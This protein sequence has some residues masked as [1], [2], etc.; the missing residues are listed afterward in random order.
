MSI[1][2]NNTTSILG[3]ATAVPKNCIDI[4]QLK[5][6]FKIDEVTAFVQE[7]AFEEV[8]HAFSLQT[9]SDLG[10]EAA[11]KLIQEKN[12]DVT[13]IGFIVFITKTPDYRSPASAIVLQHRLGIPMDCL[14]YDIN[15]GSV[16]FATGLNLGSS[17][18]SSLSTSLGLI[19]LGDTN[20][21]QTNPKD[22][23]SY[24]FGDAATAILVQKNEVSTP[25]TTE[26]IS[27]GEHYSSYIV[28]EGAFRTTDKRP[29]YELSSDP[30]VSNSNALK[31]DKN[32]FSEFIKNKLETLLSDFLEKNS[33]SFE[34]YDV[35]A[36]QQ[37]KKEL[38][39]QNI[40]SVAKNV[41]ASSN[42]NK[43]GDTSGSSVALLLKNS[44]ET[45]RVL[46]V[47]FGEGF[48]IGFA[49]FYVEPNVILPLL[50]TDNYFENGFVTHEM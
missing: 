2:K 20:S 30:S 43:F 23:N 5:S 26:I 11:T 25:I 35:I 50:E 8:R 44:E 14:A 48:S 49:D 27:F 9:A 45:Q 1:S 33:T 6:Q 21:K 38:I 12:I 19:I 15:L 39:P 31:F 29:N 24:I 42:F 36:F 32:S 22:I 41:F 7:T 10:Y 46:S 37:N 4:T 13:Q 34:D 17:L 16:G 18:L 47:S 40:L 28:K 3:I